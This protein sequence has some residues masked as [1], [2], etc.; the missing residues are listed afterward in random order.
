MMNYL[1]LECPFFEELDYSIPNSAIRKRFKDFF[2]EKIEKIEF[3]YSM[4]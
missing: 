4:T 2:L 3:N 1:L